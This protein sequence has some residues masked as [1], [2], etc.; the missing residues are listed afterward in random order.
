MAATPAELNEFIRDYLAAL[1]ARDVDFVRENSI[2]DAEAGYSGFHTGDEPVDWSI[3]STVDALSP[4]SPARLEKSA[5]TGWMIGDVAWFTD[6]PHGVLPNGQMLDDFVRLTVIAR[7]VDGDRWKVAHWH[8]S[9]QVARNL[10]PNAPAD[11]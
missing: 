4:L 6:F 8:I 1:A 5:P 3:Q 10:D 7:R 9:E 2:E 11:A